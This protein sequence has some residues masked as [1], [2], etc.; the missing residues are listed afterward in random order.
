MA[1]MNAA[2]SL[3]EAARAYACR[4]GLAVFPVGRDKRP[5]VEGGFYAA[6]TDRET[7]ARWWRLTPR[8]GIA[9]YLGKSRL[10]GLDLD[11]PEVASQVLAAFPSLPRTDWVQLTPRQG[12][13]VVAAFEDGE[14]PRTR[15]LYRE[16]GRRIGELRSAGVYLVLWP[17]ATEQGAYRLLTPGLPWEEGFPLRRFFTAEDA[18]AHL[19]GL[20]REVVPLR[21]G[22]AGR[23]PV[24]E[25]VPI[26]ENQGRN[27]ALYRVGRTLVR[28]GAPACV[29]EETLRHLNQAVCSPPLDEKELA[30]IIAHVL[31]Q[32]LPERLRRGINLAKFV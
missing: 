5:L 4:L 10:A 6:T 14:P 16:D 25:R 1:A 20:V 18:E 29:V 11:D 21:E 2:P 13:H 32:P 30:T 3:A 12:L 17:S 23:P 31:T 24:L 22:G 28:E 26:V 19:L 27:D 15:N 8:A 9:V 7:I